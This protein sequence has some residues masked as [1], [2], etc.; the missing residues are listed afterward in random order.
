MP[1]YLD[2]K[3]DLFRICLRQSWDYNRS[4][5][6][7]AALGIDPTDARTFAR[8]AIDVL[9]KGDGVKMHDGHSLSEAQARRLS[10]GRRG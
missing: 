3:H 9:Q 2:G 5:A 6:A 8:Y 10:V 7:L 4:A 1:V